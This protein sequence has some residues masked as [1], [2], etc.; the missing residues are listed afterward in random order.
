[1]ISF[2]I[3]GQLGVK[4]AKVMSSAGK[5]SS[6]KK[7]WYKKEYNQAEKLRR[8]QIKSHSQPY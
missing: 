6:N 5:T 7:N 8:K 1:M 2:R 3:S 4:E